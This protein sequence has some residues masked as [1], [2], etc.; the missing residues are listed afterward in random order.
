MTLLDPEKQGADEAGHL[1]GEAAR[2]GTDAIMVGGSTGVTQDKVDATVLA[3]K[4]AAKVP[5][6][7]FPSSARNL[8]PHA[9]ALF[10]MSLLNSRDPRLIVGEQRLAAPIVKAWALETIPMAYLVVEPG[11]RAGEVG[12]ADLITRKNPVVAV[13][14]ALAA[15]MLGMKLVYLEA[16]S[17]APDPVPAKVVRAV[18]EAIEIPIV[19]GGGI[20]TPEAAAGIAAAG[21]DVVVTGTI[22]EVAREGDALRRIIEAVKAG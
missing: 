8:S 4:E 22:V 1:A 12:N 5:V 9:D 6:I 3:I 20:R 18:R 10:F 11:M 13:Q 21:A 17:G 7:L 14:Y 16:G 15:Q 19:V 2:A